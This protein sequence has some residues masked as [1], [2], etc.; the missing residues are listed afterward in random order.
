[1]SDRQQLRD[2][3][4]QILAA[5]ERIPGRFAS[6]KAP[7]DFLTTEAGREHLDSIS[8]VLLSVGE[9][10]RDIDDRT[11]GAFLGQYPEIPWR[12]VIGMRNILAHHYFDVDEEV[13][14]NTCNQNI[15]PL[16]AVVQ[17][18]LTDLNQEG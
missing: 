16:I 6:I 13:I 5:L 8:M 1:M 4:T 10:F 15:A 2:R 17:Q 12:L 14:F 18:M 9:A 3:L 7:Q 11:K